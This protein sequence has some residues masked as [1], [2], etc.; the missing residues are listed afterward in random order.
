MRVIVSTVFFM[1]FA[2]MASP[3]AVAQKRK[4]PPTADEDTPAA[5]TTNA[6]GCY[7]DAEGTCRC[8]KRSKC[9]CPGECE[10]AGC[11]E[12]RQKELEREAQEEVKRQQEAERQRNAELEKRR[13]EQERE[14]RRKRLRGGKPVE[15]S[16]E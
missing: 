5:P 6:C 15:D 1:V 14:E 7:Q 2:F 9:G 11:E 8:V 16:P 3:A 4:Q 13:Q 10:P 12:K